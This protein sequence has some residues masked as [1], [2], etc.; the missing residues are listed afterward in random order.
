MASPRTKEAPPANNADR[1]H[2]RITSST[3]GGTAVHLVPR[4]QIKTSAF[5]LSQ[6]SQPTISIHWNGTL[7]IFTTY[8]SWLATH[9]LS[10][11][12]PTTRSD[13]TI[14]I[15]AWGMGQILQD[16]VYQYTA[17][18]T[19]LDG[20]HHWKGQGTPPFIYALTSQL[21]RTIY[22]ETP[23]D[24]ELHCIIVDAIVRFGNAQ[25]FEHFA[26]DEGYPGKFFRD[27]MVALGKAKERKVVGVPPV[28]PFAKEAVLPPFWDEEVEMETR[29]QGEY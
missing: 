23:P 18:S 22:A 26:S 19:I 7:D 13:Y 27:V 15:R 21:V 9:T 4:T 11:S 10:P 1:I 8:L 2:I 12:S 14:W 17:L 6:L 3:T 20:L 29:R 24:A 25:D 16:L 5:L 28:P